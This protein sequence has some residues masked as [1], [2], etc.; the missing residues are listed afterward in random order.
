MKSFIS[1]IFRI[2]G[3][4]KEIFVN[5]PLSELGRGDI[6]AQM[7]GIDHIIVSL[8]VRIRMDK[9]IATI[10]STHSLLLGDLHKSETPT[11][12]FSFGSPYLPEYD[13]LETYVCAFGYGEVSVRAASNALFGRKDVEGIHPV[14]LKIITR[15]PQVQ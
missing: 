4:V 1:D 2:H 8:V 13:M 14:N 3:H 11:V 9:G 12:T 10:D 6:L 15:A 5:D 7:K